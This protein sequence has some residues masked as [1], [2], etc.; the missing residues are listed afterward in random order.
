MD[1]E[2]LLTLSHITGLRRS[3]QR[4]VVLAVGSPNLGLEP[5]FV[6]LTWVLVE[7]T[8]LK[9]ITP[10]SRVA[11]KIVRG[12]EARQLVPPRI[13]GTQ[14]SAWHAADAQPGVAVVTTVH[15]PL[16]SIVEQPGTTVAGSQGR[17]RAPYHSRYA[18]RLLQFV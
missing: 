11:I 14:H 13:R 9:V 2:V 5:A 6:T 17:Q 4:T 15:Y 1:K 10:T 3:L 16:H 12:W 18:T 8:C 7:V